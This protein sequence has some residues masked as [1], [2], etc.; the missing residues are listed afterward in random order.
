MIHSARLGQVVRSRAG[1]DAGCTYVL[2][3]V[4]DQRLVAVADGRLRT[5]DNPKTKNIK[6]LEVLD[7]VDRAL[8]EKLLRGER[9]ADN[10][11]QKALKATE[12]EKE[13]ES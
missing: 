11:I 7:Y 1:R 6:H 2:C 5:V 8:E 9:V 12:V 13:V 10:E 4:I 3:K